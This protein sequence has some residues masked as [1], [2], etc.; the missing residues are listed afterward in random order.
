VVAMSLQFALQ[1]EWIEAENY[2]KK[3]PQQNKLKK[4]GVNFR[5]SYIKIDNQIYKIDSQ[6]GEGSFGKVKKGRNAQDQEVA[7]KIQGLNFELIQNE[8][9]ILNELGCLIGSFDQHFKDAKPFRNNNNNFLT[10]RKH[11]TVMSF[12]KGDNLNDKLSDDIFGRL[13]YIQKLI[14]ALR[15]CKTIQ[16]LHSNHII[17]CDIKPQNIKIEMKNDNIRVHLLD[18]GLSKIL[19]SGEQYRIE[20]MIAGTTGYIAPEIY[21]NRQYSFK[22]DIYALG[23]MF[24]KDFEL[25]DSLCKGMLVEN[26]EERDNLEK[27]IRKLNAELIENQLKLLEEKEA[28]STAKKYQLPKRNNHVLTEFQEL[29]FEVPKIDFDTR[30]RAKLFSVN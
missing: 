10:N 22:S 12:I 3:N 11:Y 28:S 26:Y 2:F 13:T 5:H 1:N 23:R 19:A 9:D 15:I 30:N 17:H 18:F 20:N 25:S 16:F 24:S 4:D 21:S 29:K 27:V 7:I 14:I 6:L 8:E